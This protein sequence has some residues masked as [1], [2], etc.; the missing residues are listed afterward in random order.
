MLQAIQLAYVFGDS[1]HNP[2]IIMGENFE[3]TIR[4]Y[5]RK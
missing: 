1:C 4:S 3:V 5:C 2:K